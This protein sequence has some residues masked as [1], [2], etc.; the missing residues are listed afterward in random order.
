MKKDGKW[1]LN[2]LAKVELRQFRTIL[3]PDNSIDII[4]DMSLKYCAI[5]E[6]VLNMATFLILNTTFRNFLA[7]KSSK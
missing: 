4:I 7:V 6:F 1:I 5:K 3:F 2:L